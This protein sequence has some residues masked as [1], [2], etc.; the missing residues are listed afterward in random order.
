M[1]EKTVQFD[2]KGIGCTGTVVVSA[3]NF[4]R[5]GSHSCSAC[6]PP[7][8][9]CTI[10]GKLHEEDETPAKNRGGDSFFFC[11]WSNRRKAKRRQNAV[12][13]TYLQCH[14][15]F[16]PDFVKAKSGFFIFLLLQFLS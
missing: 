10:C 9:P 3:E 8:Y 16:C 4:L 1:S 2:C 14:L 7:L 5:I 12:L 13:L 6:S 11:W 15:K